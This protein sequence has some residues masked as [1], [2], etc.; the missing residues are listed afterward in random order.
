MDIERLYTNKKL[1]KTKQWVI[2]MDICYDDF[3][4]DVENC[5]EPVKPC[6][7][8]GK[9]SEGQGEGKD[10]KNSVS[11]HIYT[12]WS[13]EKHGAVTVINSKGETS[14]KP[15]DLFDYIIFSEK[16]VKKE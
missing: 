8:I 5:G 14:S 3:K 9:S 1:V 2:G 11:N 4:C 7:N 16:E 12:Y 13:C 10:W 15:S 6:A